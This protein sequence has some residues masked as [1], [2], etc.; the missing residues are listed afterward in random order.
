DAAQSLARRVAGLSAADREHALLDLVRG[1]VAAVLGHA[2]AG[3]VDTARA[4]TEIGFDSLTAV[5]LRNRLTVATGL[6][7]PPTLVFTYPTPADLARHLGAEIAPA[8][9]A[10]PPAAEELRRLDAALAA[11]PAAG[12]VRDGV[13]KQL[14]ALVRKWDRAEEPPAV[15]WMS[16]ESVT[17]DDMFELLDRELGPAG[18]A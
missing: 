6:R 13:L 14:Q 16:A 1:H 4:F 2:S 11:L 18:N 9:E 15:D 17:D 5:E 7:L 8:A 12:D 3:A 10:E